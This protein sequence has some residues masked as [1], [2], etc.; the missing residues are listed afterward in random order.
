[1]ARIVVVGAGVSGLAAARTVAGPLAAAK[2]RHEVVLIEGSERLGGKIA[3]ALVDGFVIE[4]GPDSFLTRKPAGVELCRELGIDARFVGRSRRGH[5]SYLYRAGRLHPLPE[6]F[7]GLVP[8]DPKALEATTLLSEEAKARLLREP[9]IP[10]RT[11]ADSGSDA[12]SEESVA[13]FMARRF[14]REAFDAMIEPLVSGIFAGDAGL[15]SMQAAFP[16][17]V[18][19]ER[20]RGRLSS[21]PSSDAGRPREGSPPPFVS[22]PRGMGEL[23]D[24]LGTSLAGVRLLTGC[25]VASLRRVGG[26][27]AVTLAEG[28][29]ERADAVVLAV[30]PAAAAALVEEEHGPLA[31]RLSAVEYASTVVVSIGYRTADLAVDLDGYGYLSPKVEGRL[32][33]ACTWSSSKWPGRAP[34]GFSLIRLYG[35]R[36]GEHRIEGLSEEELEHEAREELAHTLAIEAEPTVVRVKRWPEAIP[37]YNIGYGAL[38]R[39]VEEALA[40]APGLFLAGAAYGGGVGI[41][42]CIQSGRTAARGAVEYLRSSGR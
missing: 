14:G 27:I 25:R 2:E 35:G 20:T 5:G 3:T 13:S 9:E 26:E 15:L 36:Y 22:F 8:S 16:Q 38:R 24:A 34:A 6:G 21:G 18:E 19:L 1:M 40:A 12:D 11:D 29:E 17:L 28:E 33:H 39:A 41:P 4:E 37:Q 10:R 32:F 42:D 31:E 23:V 30:P 7:S